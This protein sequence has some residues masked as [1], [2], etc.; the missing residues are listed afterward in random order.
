MQIYK[1][2]NTIHRSVYTA[3][4]TYKDS[5]YYL[6]NCFLTGKFALLT[7]KQKEI[8]EHPTDYL[9][10]IIIPTLLEYGFIQMKMN[11]LYL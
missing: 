11:I 3:C 9:S 7:E 10:E 4:V 1:S 2:N 8:F 5:G 6:V